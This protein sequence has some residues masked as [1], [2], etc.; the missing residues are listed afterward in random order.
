MAREIAR[1]QLTGL[2]AI[3]LGCIAL[4]I[5]VMGFFAIRRLRRKLIQ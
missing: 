2:F 1:G 4:F 5:V 3:D